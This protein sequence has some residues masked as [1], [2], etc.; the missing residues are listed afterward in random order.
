MS[1]S[2]SPAEARMHFENLNDYALRIAAERDA[3]REQ[4]RNVDRRQADLRREVKHL[5][6]DNHRL[7]EEQPERIVF[8]KKIAK[9]ESSL[10]QCTH[11]LKETAHKLK[12]TGDYLMV[13]TER[14]C[15]AEEA[16]EARKS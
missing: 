13:M 1:E 9:L 2:A 11:K 3:L 7:R 12:E 15:E 10:S 4:L 16:L 5:I 8:E 6:A 14:A